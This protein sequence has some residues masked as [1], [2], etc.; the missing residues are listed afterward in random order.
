MGEKIR[1]EKGVLKVPDNPVIPYIEG[2]GTGP[3]IWKA[4]VRVF[5]AAVERVYKGGK[6]IIWKE[7]LAGE[8]A[9]RTTGD[10]L[11]GET[12]SA[13]REYL[14]GKR[15]ADNSCR[16]GHALFERCFTPGAGSLHLLPACKIFC[17]CSQS[18]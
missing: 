5:D 6:K 16:W 12:L 4:S 17:R 7:V 18:G 9:F 13:F 10:W 2:D 11:P 1:I 3:D 14:V 8:K 15:S